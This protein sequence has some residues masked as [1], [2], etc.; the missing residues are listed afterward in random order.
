MLNTHVHADHVT[1]SGKIK[2]LL[3]G[4][5]KSVIS[6]QSSAKADI[7]VDENNEL[8]CGSALKLKVLNT[9]GH[10]NGCVTYVDSE[11]RFAFTG[12][13]LLIRGCGRTDFQEGEEH[14]QTKS[15]I[16]SDCQQKYDF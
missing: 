12:D 9:P 15:P 11:N 14:S 2:S 6:R 1:G 7:F 8:S 4:Q 16:L 13:A 5:V 10:T 3:N